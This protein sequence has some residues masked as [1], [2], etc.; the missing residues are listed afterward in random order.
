MVDVALS[1]LALL[2]GLLT[3]AAFAALEVPIP[4]PPELPGVLGIVGIYAGYKLIQ[5]SGV[6]YDLLG[7]LGI[8][9]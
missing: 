2:T 9:G 5:W 8:G 3:G 7:L 4:A 1:T 6:S